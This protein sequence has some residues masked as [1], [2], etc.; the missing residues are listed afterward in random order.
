MNINFDEIYHFMFETFEG[1]IILICSSL[2]I[3][4]IACIIME[5]RTKKFLKARQEARA[6]AQK[7]K[8]EAEAEEDEAEEK[9]EEKEDE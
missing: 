2:V 1:V 4:I 3:C 6:K 7:E 8:E 9:A 5:F